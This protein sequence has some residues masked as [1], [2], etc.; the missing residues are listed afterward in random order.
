MAKIKNNPKFLDFD[1]IDGRKHL[2]DAMQ[3]MTPQDT[4]LVLDIGDG[5]PDDSYSSVAYEKGFTFLLYLERLVG[6]TEFENFFKAYIAR[7]A[8]H[9]LTSLDFKQFFLQSFK[10]NEKIKEID[11]DKWFYGEGMPPVLPDLD[12]SMAMESQNLAS[13][14]LS[15]DRDGK[16]SPKGNDMASWSSL[17]ITCF[18]D[19]LALK[20]GDKP[21]KLSTLQAMNEL[22]K[23][24]ESR[25]SEV[26]YR[27]CELAI[28]A[29]DTSVIPV[30][31]RFITSQGRMKFVRPLFRALYKSKMGKD[32]ATSR[33]CGANCL[34]TLRTKSGRPHV[35]MES[36]CG[37]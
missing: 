23:F 20:L 1:A 35:R 25:N 21:L 11:W 36:Y 31:V 30:A 27:Y 26:L 28:P 22:Y 8:S 5:D 17:Q 2:L 15:V 34:V 9:I 37:F 6:T 7:F 16:A 12:Q 10:G 33:D 24:S 29:E 13:S 32:L 18:L 19:D 4:R 3:E 14:W